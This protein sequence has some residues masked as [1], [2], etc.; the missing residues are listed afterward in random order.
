MEI[1]ISMLK[2]LYGFDISQNGRS[3]VM[4]SAG[5]FF[6]SSSLPSPSSSAPSSLSLSLSGG[7]LICNPAN[8]GLVLMGSS[9]VSSYPRPC[10]PTGYSASFANSCPRL[11]GHWILALPSEMRDLLRPLFWSPA[12]RL[13]GW[14]QENGQDGLSPENAEKRWS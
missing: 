7:H 4:S 11:T 14:V 13:V 6:L 8:D 3:V 5:L 9:H 2:R 1:L 12:R 10:S